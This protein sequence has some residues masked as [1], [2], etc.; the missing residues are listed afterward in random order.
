M[1]QK[2]LLRVEVGG[3]ACGVRKIKVQSLSLSLVA[4]H[5]SRS[6]HNWA[7][8]YAE[9]THTSTVPLLLFIIFRLPLPGPLVTC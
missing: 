9:T 4:A 5:L 3:C 7:I 6:D 2:Q 8:T 1:A